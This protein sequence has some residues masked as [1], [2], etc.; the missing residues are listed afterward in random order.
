ME[1]QEHDISLKVL[2]QRSVIEPGEAYYYLIVRYL[3]K[4]CIFGWRLNIY[5]A[6][7]DP[8]IFLDRKIGGPLLAGY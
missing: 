1:S 2:F 3:V 6:S 8:P 4:N 7:R 5:P